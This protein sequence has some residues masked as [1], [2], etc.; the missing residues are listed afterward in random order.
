MAW[1]VAIEVL[2]K[3]GLLLGGLM[4]AAA[5][6]VLVERWIAAWVQDRLGPNRVGIPLT[7]IRLFGLGQ[8]IADGVKFIC[9]EEFTPAHVDRVLYTL[10]PVMMLVAAL[11]AFAVIPFGSVLPG[12]TL[13]DG[14][15]YQIQLVLLPGLDAGIL[16]FLAFGGIGVFGV[17]LGGWASNNKYSFFGGVRSAAQLI[18]YEVPLG[19]SILAIVLAAGSLR[20]D[21]IIL[22]QADTG[23]WNAFVQPLGFLVFLVAVCAEA[24]RLPFD[25]AEAEQELVGGYHTEYSG[26]RL[27]MFLVSEFLH[28]IAASFLIVILF[29]GGWHFWGLTGSGLEV[30]WGGALL[31]VIVLVAKVFLVILGFMLVRWSWPRFRFDQLMDLAW[32]VLLSWGLIH[33]LLVAAWMYWANEWP[34]WTLAVA[35]WVSLVVVWIVTALISPP[36]CDNRPRRE[37]GP[38]GNVT[39]VAVSAA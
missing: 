19:L 25:L 23:W 6:L 2:V 29:L 1:I 17:A 8:P 13:P 22:A 38:V 5:Y 3:I 32:K 26:M 9:K 18:S 35:N 28:M 16:L 12:F 27:M 21:R 31:R 30:G 15:V 20:L 14:T 7:R 39:P 37:L 36:E 4:F 10:A 24:G 34:V 11:A 33:V